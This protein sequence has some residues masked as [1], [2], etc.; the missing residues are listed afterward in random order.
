MI[1]FDLPRARDVAL[2]HQHDRKIIP[3]T[4]FY[5]RK[6]PDRKQKVLTKMSYFVDNC[7]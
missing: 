4:E 5:R 3:S 2:L 7:L 1:N 6:M